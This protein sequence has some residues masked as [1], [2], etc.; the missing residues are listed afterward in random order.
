MA[1]QRPEEPKPKKTLLMSVT[2][3]FKGIQ[4]PFRNVKS[5]LENEKI[6]KYTDKVQGMDKKQ[7]RK[8]LAG[9][10]GG[11][12]LVIYL[13]LVHVYSNRFIDG[14]IINGID[15]GSK[16]PEQVEA[17]LEKRIESYTLS[18]TMRS[19]KAAAE[20][21]EE[22]QSIGKEEPEQSSD[23]AM[24]II[25][26]VYAAEGDASVQQMSTSSPDSAETVEPVEA[27][28]SDTSVTDSSTT[29]K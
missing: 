2:E 23:G 10:V 24:E 16:T 28:D 25:A 22:V 17:L 21:M 5:P 26:P 20:Y 19:T 15:V 11:F 12:L 4:N 6:R 13:I 9:I 14:T 27:S 8:L 7:G 3:F 18:L 29:G 1:K